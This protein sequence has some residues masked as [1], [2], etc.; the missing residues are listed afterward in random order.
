MNQQTIFV[1]VIV[2]EANK[3][4]YALLIITFLFFQ[5]QNYKT[6]YP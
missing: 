6:L 2:I 5:L 1:T 3:L 4:L